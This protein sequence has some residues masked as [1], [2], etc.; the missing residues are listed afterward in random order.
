[1]TA[2]TH[3]QKPQPLAMKKIFKTWLPL[4]ASWML[5]SMELPTINA[6]MARLANPEINMAAYGGV[7]FPIALT[8]EAPVIMLLAAS[9]ALSRDWKSYQQVKKIT[10]AMGIILAGLHLLVAITPIYD[11]IVNVILQAPPEV[12]EPGRIGLLF[13]TPWTLG[14]AYRRFQQ[15]AM[16]RFDHSHMVGET[17]VVRLVT[18]GI[19]LTIGMLVKT[20]PGTMVAGMA[21]GLGVTAEAIYAGLRIRKIR[22]K[23][24]EAPPAQKPL[25]IKRFAAFYAPLIFTASVWLLWMPVVSATVSRMPNPLESLAV[26]SVLTGLLF[27]FRSPGVAFNEAVVA[28]LEEPRSFPAL[29]RFT[30]L[31]SLVTMVIAALI[32]ATP[33]SRLWFVFV[34]NLKPDQVQVAQIALGMGIPLTVLSFLAHFYQG[35]IV[36]REKTRGVAEAVG[37]FMLALTVVLIAG[38]ISGSFKGV[39][40]ATAAFVIAHLAQAAWLW[41]RSRKSRKFLTTRAQH[42]FSEVSLE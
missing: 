17:T 28:L 2:Q 8:I 10:L 39:F 15:G 1:M 26:W 20:L 4:L 27:F 9:T 31:M 16:I 5:M 23:I 12:V 40:V 14:I 6:I 36:Y 32:V 34:A 30:W 37:I 29:R 38:V 11:F 33:L 21:Q 13:M 18:V 3:S 42:V 25:T 41:V 24:K 22:P 35:I 19:V 7:V